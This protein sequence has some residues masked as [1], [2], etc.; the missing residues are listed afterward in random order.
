MRQLSYKYCCCFYSEISCTECQFVVKILFKY[1][2]NDIQIQ[3]KY[4]T[5][6]FIKNTLGEHDANIG[7]ILVKYFTS[8][9][10][11]RYKYK[12]NN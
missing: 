3:H 7:E 10:E 11:I 5:N 1:K 6:T 4:C 9:T 8:D 12:T 2:A